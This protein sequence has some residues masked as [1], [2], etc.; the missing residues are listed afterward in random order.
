MLMYSIF[1]FTENTNDTLKKGQMLVSLLH[2]YKYTYENKN[3]V[4]KSFQ[5]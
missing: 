1:I 3:T 5:E 2:I 4:G